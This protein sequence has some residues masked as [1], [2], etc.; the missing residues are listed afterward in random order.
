MTISSLNMVDA[1]CWIDS[2]ILFL[3]MYDFVTSFGYIIGKIMPKGIEFYDIYDQRLETFR[4]ANSLACKPDHALCL[5]RISPA[6]L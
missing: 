5:K 3:D 6:L 4:M 1:G 2:R